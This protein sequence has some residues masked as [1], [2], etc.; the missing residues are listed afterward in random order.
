MDIIILGAGIVGLTMANLLAKDTNLKIAIIEA[1]QINLEWDNTTYDL[2]CSAIN[3]ASQNIFKHL[4][5]WDTIHS[6]RVGVYDKMQVWEQN[7]HN[8]I[9]F[10]AQTYGQKDLGHIVEN[11]V[12]QAALWQKLKQ[13]ENVTVLYGSAVRIE[14]SVSNTSVYF[15]DERIDAK[16]IIGADGANS[17][18]RSAAGIAHTEHDYQQM[19]LVATV[20]TAQAHHNTAM[21][22]FSTTGNLAF[23]PLD[24]PNTMSI[25]WVASPT[26]IQDLMQHDA[27]KFC[28][29]LS[30][31]LQSKLG[32][33]ELC[34]KRANFPLRNLRAKNYITEGIALVGDAAHVVHPLAGQGLNL[35][36]M[37]AAVLSEIIQHATMNNDNFASHKL[38]RKYEK[39]RK[40]YN[41]SMLVMIDL[42]KTLYA[43]Q[44]SWIQLLRGSGMR[45]L[46][47]LSFVKR[48]M[49]MFALGLN[50]QL[51][52]SAKGI[53]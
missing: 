42:I 5:I 22:R 45:I 9:N 2:R 51:P 21:Q 38:L 47:D 33:I 36:I 8:S 26:V 30:D 4:A 50:Q 44:N 19:A 16:L 35:G 41:A 27:V 43:T 34:G 29:N 39:N 10:D 32:A 25:V 18:L 52:D 24:E 28:S 53:Y 11:R 15:Y 17:W 3:R 1:Q 23:L 49:A 14:H 13:Q 6:S 20:K 46:N 7:E 12:M 37:D 31:A 40:G 48:K